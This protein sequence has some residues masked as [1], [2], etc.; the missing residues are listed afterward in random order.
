PEA[1]T[2]LQVN[3]DDG[4]EADHLFSVLM[5]SDIPPRSQFIQENAKYVRNLDI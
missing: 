3:L 4:A 1:R 2:L 5:G